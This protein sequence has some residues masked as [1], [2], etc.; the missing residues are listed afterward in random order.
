MLSIAL[1]YGVTGTILWYACKI[2]VEYAA[3]QS[4]RYDAILALVNGL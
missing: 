3:I 4:A 2:A 1:K